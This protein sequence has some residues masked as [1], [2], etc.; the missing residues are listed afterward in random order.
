MNEHGGVTESRRIPV[1]E[2]FGPTVQGEGSVIGRKTM[3]VRTAGCDYSCAWCDSA[4]TWDGSG[5]ADIRLMTAQDIYAELRHIGGDTFAH[6][7]IS[8]GNPALLPQLDELVELLHG[9]GI[10]VALET[11]GSRW[12]DWFWDID[13]LTLSPKPPSSRM[14]T[15]WQTLDGII[16]KLTERERPF[17]LKVVVFDDADLQ[18]AADVH[19]RYSQ[20]PFYA[21][22]GNDQLQ[23]TEP[24]RL[25]PYLLERY[26]WLIDR[27]MSHTGLKQVHV[28]PQLH[29]WVWGNKKGV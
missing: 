20:V 27:V 13:D 22:V 18:Y 11:Q 7:T 1:I 19:E 10:R 26:E 5:K 16:A 12:Q 25:L 6:V 14:E 29:T 4:F 23:E 2:I 28:L 24:E 17:T 15:N 3:F 8:G 21:Q 9:H